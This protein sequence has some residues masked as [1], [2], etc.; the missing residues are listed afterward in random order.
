M[1]KN[2]PHGL[3]SLQDQANKYALFKN[4][5]LRNIGI[6]KNL[7]NKPDYNKPKKTFLLSE[8]ERLL[9]IA[10]SSIR[11]K[12]RAGKIVY[13]D[14]MTGENKKLY[15]LEDLNTIRA[16]FNKGFFNGAVARPPNLSPWLSPSVCLKAVLAKPRKQHI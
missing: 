6:L 2:K 10:R 5:G 15:T 13:K 1:L 14:G 4:D 3:G 16:A 9:E 11:D 12:E 8:V 7:L